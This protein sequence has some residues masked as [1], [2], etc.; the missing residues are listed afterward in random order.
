MT[1]KVNIQDLPWHSNDQHG[2][3][4]SRKTIGQAAN[5]Q[6]LGASLYRL[7]PGDKA[8]PYHAHLGNEEAILVIEGQGTLRLNNDML[9]IKKDDYI[10]LP[11]GEKHAH[12]MINTSEN[13]L[14]YLCIST[15][16]EPEVMLYPDSDKVGIMTGS[17]PGAKKHDHSF[18]AF[19]KKES[20]VDYYTDE[21]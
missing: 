17:A 7:E 6:Q 13:N 8:F 14:I 12:Q 10:A 19:Y 15:M 1:N 16:H 4:S 20:D 11:A 21:K 18:K 2:F 9:A 5:S 3:K